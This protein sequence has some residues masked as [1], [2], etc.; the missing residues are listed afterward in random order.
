MFIYLSSHASLHQTSL[1][2]LFLKCWKISWSL[3]FKHPDWMDGAAVCN[4]ASSGCGLTC[5][6]PYSR[7]IQIDKWVD[8]CWTGSEESL[9]GSKAG[10]HITNSEQPQLLITARSATKVMQ[11][12]MSLTYVW[13]CVLL[14]LRRLYYNRRLWHF[15]DLIAGA[16][17]L[18]K[19]LRVKN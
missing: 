11:R 15:C 9:Q 5:L 7:L 8:W 19:L 6:S 12:C 18:K 14:Y 2:T 3:Q 17:E 13:V 16:N 4:N 1:S 10:R